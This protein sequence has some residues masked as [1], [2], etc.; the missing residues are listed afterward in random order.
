MAT[1]SYVKSKLGDDDMFGVERIGNQQTINYLQGSMISDQRMVRLFDQNAGITFAMPR[2]GFYQMPLNQ[3]WRANS[4]NFVGT[5]DYVQMTPKMPWRNDIDSY[6]NQRQQ[7]EEW[8]KFLKEC[9]D[10]GAKETEWTN[11]FISMIFDVIGFWMADNLIEAG[12]KADSA[13]QKY[14]RI[15]G[16]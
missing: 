3:D 16:N 5:T 13:M 10:L 9:D 15:I 1:L 7:A 14:R 8:K 4:G 12:H 6:Q 2:Q 11:P